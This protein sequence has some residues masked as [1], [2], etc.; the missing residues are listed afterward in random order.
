MSRGASSARRKEPSINETRGVLM[1]CS[2]SPGP[3]Y[4]SQLPLLPHPAVKY[5]DWTQRENIC[6]LCAGHNKAAVGT[7]A[8]PAPPLPSLPIILAYDAVKGCVVQCSLY[9]WTRP[10]P[11]FSF[12]FNT[13]GTHMRSSQRTVIVSPPDGG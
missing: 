13:A 3:C 5:P 8:H 12:L 2:W 11:L 7:L 4:W 10:A 1:D 9:Y 6:L